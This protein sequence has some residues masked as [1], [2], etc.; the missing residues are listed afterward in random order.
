M[1]QTIQKALDYIEDNLKSE[2]NVKELA[3]MSNY[4]V[5][6]FYRLFQTATGMPVMQY[7]L[8]RRLL[9][10]VYAMKTN[11]KIDVALEFGFDTYAGFYRAF[12]RM[13]QYTPSQYLRLGLAK[14]PFRPDLTKE[15]TMHITHKKAREILKHWHMEEEPLYDVYYDV[16]GNRNENALN[17]GEK[18]FLKFTENLGK[19]LRH[20]NLSAQLENAGLPAATAI[21]TEDGKPYVQ[22]GE[23]YFTLTRRIAGKPMNALKM[24]ENHQAALAGELIGLLHQAL[25][26]ADGLVEKSDFFS[27]IRDWALAKAKETVPLSDGF[28]QEYLDAIASFDSLLPR[29]CIHRDPNPGNIIVSEDIW[30]FVDFELSEHNIRLYDPCYAATAVLSETYGKGKREEWFMVY[31]D[32]LEGYDRT[33][34]LTAEEKAAAPWVVLGNQMICVAYFATQQKYRELYETN[35]QMFRFL[36]E[37]RKKLELT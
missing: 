11:K 37:N 10:A 14:K 6:H 8:R 5:F 21:L 7:I 36:L 19:L 28:C 27:A 17:V 31:H 23:T 22:D 16:T 3:D 2:L 1:K 4:S 30:G 20:Q 34:H 33:A 9:H 29:Q 35:L 25:K 15:E 18:Y 13:F 26:E 12:Q 24:Y 32:I